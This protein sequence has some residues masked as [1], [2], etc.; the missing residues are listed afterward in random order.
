MWISERELTE[1]KKQIRSL[2]QQINCMGDIHE[3]QL[4]NYSSVPEIRCGVC[5]K[6]YEQPQ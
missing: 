2:Q 4:S 3:W 6:R 5:F 1:L